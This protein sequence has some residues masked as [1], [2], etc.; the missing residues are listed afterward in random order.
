MHV[1]PLSESLRKQLA[2]LKNAIEG[3]IRY[4][5]TYRLLY[6]TDASVYREIPLAVA[7]PKNTNDI[8]LLISTA[9]KL[10]VSVIPRTAG[11]SLAGQVVGKGIVADV[12]KY[13]TQII[14]L[15]K[16]EKWV[17]VQ[18]GVI[19][20]ELNSY[21]APQGLFFGPETSTSNRCMLGG[22]V[23]NNACGA[24]SLIYGSTRDHI[25]AVEVVL[26]D[27]SVVTFGPAS[28]NKILEK[29]AADTLEG[30][31]YKQIIEL[32]NDK[33][34]QKSIRE[35]FPKPSVKRRNTGY[36]IDII[37]E[38]QPFK[39][40]GSAFNLA[41]LI[42]GSEGTL[43]FVTEIKLNLVDKPP[44][45]KGLLCAH[46]NSINESL[47]ANLIA[48]QH[49]PVSIELIDK[50]IVECTNENIEQRKNRFF[51]EGTP[52]AIL[53]IEFFDTSQKN[54][55][56][57]ANALIEDLKTRGLGYHFP[58]VY[59]ADINKVWALRKAG[60]GLLSNVK[61]DAK[62]VAVIEDTAVDV[63][64]LP[65][66]INDFQKVLEKYQLSCV[67]YAHAATGELHL[68]PVLNLKDEKHVGIFRAV[69]YDIADLVKKYRGSLSGEH[70]DGRLRSELI[71]LMLGEKNYEL[72]KQIKHLWDPD[73]VFN[74]HK[75]IDSLPL[76][77][78]LRYDKVGAVKL[79]ATVFD[80][81]N[82]INVLGAAEACNG[83]ADCRKTLAA[84]GLM[85]PSYMATLDE[86][87]STRA[88]A[89]IL[90]E[91]LTHTSKSNPFHHKEIFE[92]MDLCLSCKACKS[93]CPSNVDIAKLKSEFLYHYYKASGIPLRSRLTA[94][95]ST[96]NSVGSIAPSLFNF[97]AEN[98]TSANILK[99]IL[100]FAPQRVIPSLYKITLR[101]W[102]QKNL[103]E[104]NKNAWQSAKVLLFIDEFTN[105]NDTVIGMK[106]MKLLSALGYYIELLSA[107]NSGRAFI[108]KGALKTA[109]KMAEKNVRSTA[110]AIAIHKNA[111]VVGVEPSAILSF[112]DEY[113][114]LVKKPLRKVAHEIAEKV[115]MLDEFLAIEIDKKNISKDIF[116]DKPKKIYVHGHCHQ[117]ALASIEPTKKVL[118]FPENFEVHEIKSSCCG[119]AGSFG[120]EKEHYEVSQKIGEM[121]LFPAVRKAEA[122]SLICAPG[123][124]CRQQI[125]EAT[126]RSV[127]HPA[128]ILFDAINNER[129]PL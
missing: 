86:L 54:I 92:A 20:D 59:G 45:H 102:A 53:I 90:R 70:G 93:E 117:K 55:D 26:S 9:R 91:F 63:N 19:L 18:P 56:D 33:E 61:G 87:H 75:I 51:I 49:K 2:H 1:P 6:A 119:M 22:M 65:D 37:L 15:N 36:A 71:P 32:L 12:S 68:R 42:A 122:V 4:T 27:G 109:Q 24:H 31:I 41:K 81:S 99:K 35:G 105:Y 66:Y 3:D 43:A 69:L 100:G 29:K 58:L 88:R 110:E 11:T 83:S 44:Q 94:H 118:S 60:L 112:R 80:F 121:V 120:Y 13:M 16:E 25:N 128:E 72:L 67:Y 101:K 127:L 111:F 96:V 125:K 21:L 129:K 124:S 48:L 14:E 108:S 89:N 64:D 23:G 40:D 7:Y 57:R 97:I 73:G 107:G 84:G 52:A 114:D 74:K 10:G 79:P 116:S 76:D 46:F 8:A 34:N 39:A 82:Q 5:D 85:C 77:T 115:Y 104:L 78:S 126:G 123:T 103:H 62:P 98:K 95:I 113:P 38:Q 17:R 30:R 47:K 28:P 106:T 50:V